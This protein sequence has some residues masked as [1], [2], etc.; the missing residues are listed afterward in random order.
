M[1]SSDEE[2]ETVGRLPT[3]SEVR[4]PEEDG[5]V[6]AARS[7]RSQRNLAR[8]TGFKDPDRNT[9]HWDQLLR[10]M[11]WMAEDFIRERKWRLNQAKIFARRAS[12]ALQDHRVKDRHHCR[13]DTQRRMRKCAAIAREV[14]RFWR[15]A[16]RVVNFKVQQSIE[17]RKKEM[18][19][20]HL[21]FLVGQ[22]ERYSSMLAENLLGQEGGMVESNGI[23]DGGDA[24]GPSNQ[25]MV[26]KGNANELEQDDGPGITKRTV[27][28]EERL[29]D[30]RPSKRHRSE[31]ESGGPAEGEEGDPE[32]INSDILDAGDA[33]SESGSEEYEGEEQD[34]E[35]TLEE[36]EKLAAA[37]ASPSRR[38]NE[39]SCLE[40]EADLPLE[41]ILKSY[42]MVITEKCEVQRMPN[43]GENKEMDMEVG[44]SHRPRVNGLGSGEAGRNLR[45]RRAARRRDSPPNGR[46][47]TDFFFFDGGGNAGKK[48]VT[49]DGGGG[50]NATADAVVGAT[51]K[52]NG[53]S[54]PGHASADVE[55]K[56]DASVEEDIQHRGEGSGL[57][58][59]ELP[60]ETVVESSG[61]EASAELPR[62]K[63]DLDGGAGKAEE[64]EA[65]A[66]SKGKAVDTLEDDQRVSTGGQN[67]TDSN[68]LG[69][70]ADPDSSNLVDISKVASTAQPKGNTLSACDVRTNVPFLLKHTLREY[71]HIGLDWLVTL[72]R[73]R[74][75]GI[76]ADEMGLGKTIQTIS[77]LAWLACEEGVWGPHL[78]V[79]PTSVMLNWEMEFKKWCPAFKLLTYYGSAKE[80]KTKRQGWSKPNAFHVCITSY[81]L[82]LQDAKMFRRKK[83]KYLILDEAHMIKNWK[84]QRWQTLLKFNSK[85]RL[86]L[87]G[88]PLQ[89]ELMELWSLM[90]FLMPHVFSSHA[91]FKDWFCNPLTGMVQGQAEVNQNIVE[92]LHGVLRPFLLRRL[93]SEVERQLPQ[94]HEHVV[95]CRLSKRQRKLYEEY[96]A[97][98]ETRSTLTSGNFLGMINVLMQLRKVC[99]HPDLFAGRPI[100]SPWDIEPIQ[101]KYPSVAMGLIEPQGPWQQTNLGAMGFYPA[102]NERMSNWEAREIGATREDV[103]TLSKQDERVT[104]DLQVESRER[105]IKFRQEGVTEPALD[106]L[107]QFMHKTIQTRREWRML[108]AQHADKL[109]HIRCSQE[110]IY[111]CDLRK[112]VGCVHPVSDGTCLPRN[113]SNHP[114]SLREMIKSYTRRSSECDTMM[115]V[116]LCCIPKARAATPVHWCSK[117]TKDMIRLASRNRLHLEQECRRR[118]ALLWTPFVRSQLF[119]PDKRLVQFDCGKLQELALL[120]HTLRSGGHRVLIFTQMS[121]MLDIL[122]LFLN[123]HGFTYMR[124]DG[125]TKPEQRQILMQK[126]NNDSRTFAFILSTRSGGVGVNLTGADTVIFYDSDWNPAMDLQAQDRCHRIGQTREVHIYRLVTEHTIEENILRKSNEKR[127]LDFLAIQSGGFNLDFLQKLNPRDLLGGTSDDEIKAA[128][129]SAEDEADATAAAEAEKEAAAEL[130]EFTAD[131]PPV[132]QADR[133][134]PEIDLENEAEPEESPKQAPEADTPRNTDPPPAAPEV[135]ATGDDNSGEKGDGRRGGERQVEETGQKEQEGNGSDAGEDE[136]GFGGLNKGMV[137]SEEMVKLLESFT[138]I[139][140]FAIQSIEQ[141]AGKVDIEAAAHQLVA[142]VNEEEWELDAIEEQKEQEDQEID[143]EDELWVD[144]WDKTA[145]TAE[146]KTEVEAAQKEAEEERKRMEEYMLYAASLPPEPEP[147]TVPMRHSKRSKAKDSSTTN[148][149]PKRLRAPLSSTSSMTAS[150]DEMSDTQ[151]AFTRKRSRVNHAANPPPPRTLYDNLWQRINPPMLSGPQPWKVEDDLVLGFMVK[152]AIEGMALEGEKSVGGLLIPE[153]VWMAAAEALERGVSEPGAEFDEMET[154]SVP[155]RRSPRECKLR[156]SQLLMSFANSSIREAIQMPQNQ[157][158]FA[159]RDFQGILSRKVAEAISNAS[160]EEVMSLWRGMKPDGSSR[161]LPECFQTLQKTLNGF[162]WPGSDHGLRFNLDSGTR[163]VPLAADVVLSTIMQVHGERGTKLNK[164]LL[165]VLSDMD[166]VA[167]SGVLQQALRLALKGSKPRREVSG[168]SGSNLSEERL[169]GLPNQSGMKP[170]RMG[171]RDSDFWPPPPLPA[172]RGPPAN[173][174]ISY[175]PQAPRFPGQVNTSAQGPSLPFSSPLPPQY[176]TGGVRGLPTSFPQPTLP[177][178]PA[179]LPHGQQGYSLPPGVIFPYGGRGG[180]DVQHVPLPRPGVPKNAQP[181]DQTNRTAQILG[182]DSM[183]TLLKTLHPRDAALPVSAPGSSLQWTHLVPPHLQVVGSG[184]TSQPGPGYLP[185]STPQSMTPTFPGA[186]PPS[187]MY[188]FFPGGVGGQPGG[189]RRVG[190]APIGTPQSSE[191]FLRSLASAQALARGEKQRPPTQTGAVFGG[192]AQRGAISGIGHQPTSSGD[193]F[194]GLQRSIPLSQAES[195]SQ[196]RLPPGKYWTCG[197]NPLGGGG[198]ATTHQVIPE[199]LGE[200]LQE[201]GL[202]NVSYRDLTSSQ[203]QEQKIGG[204]HISL[205]DWRARHF[206]GR[207]KA[208]PGGAV[209]GAGAGVPINPKQNPAQSALAPLAM[210]GVSPSSGPLPLGL[211]DGAGAGIHGVQPFAGVGGGQR[212]QQPMLLISSPMP[213]ASGQMVQHFLVPISLSQL[214][215]YQTGGMNMQNLAFLPTIDRQLALRDPAV[216]GVGISGSMNSNVSAISSSGV[217]SDL[218]SG[219]QLEPSTSHGL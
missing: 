103:L 100:I 63:M 85:R 158:I 179:Y 149:P 190:A 72:Y 188:G 124:L 88:T 21:D 11:K 37:E 107:S 19:D 183:E 98:S 18:L 176:F 36:E 113:W 143:M 160:D 136:E 144:A 4:K 6:K 140:K 28:S 51:P 203:L 219:G 132:L 25:Q 207:E 151:A 189:S 202:K 181:P 84:S 17:R 78:I 130:A 137:G 208:G 210:M 69:E 129:R 187:P 22:T 64:L 92:R 138:P 164:R 5:V 116:F 156:Y 111:G 57:H 101:Y 195:L 201:M 167:T 56:D 7:I 89:N 73:K 9:T 166:K 155:A 55:Q 74:I 15:M 180:S 163:V 133:N 86:L 171:R 148:R 104:N 118:A 44:Q 154:G 108:R 83:W 47:E 168:R 61:T 142:D 191:D 99:N 170:E 159:L 46:D 105:I 106:V 182:A 77:L 192:N 112:A 45:S 12:R 209:G 161:T 52:A 193:V 26:E 117:P 82:I 157:C 197:V 211:P 2:M 145:A 62:S 31:E 200:K 80:R 8:A 114:P 14:Q 91:Q 3:A 90:H 1:A 102:W 53:N 93:K 95:H 10:E 24:A 131:P 119:F 13:D 94:K 216:G 178:G 212:A 76:L 87:T 20:K 96:M 58:E 66:P 35:G 54:D 194:V 172:Y 59:Q 184:G 127:H 153:G 29:L 125:S 198:G 177:T 115:K 215:T 42:G 122:E 150:D 32:V 38:E 75:N 79:V 135:G 123:L 213:T 146:Y 70:E 128:M 67:P 120:L 196:S 147:D 65:S 110:P 41:E 33:V 217:Q 48:F 60:N 121:K 30:T 134:D 141:M 206:A 16:E 152:H 50:K 126:F 204:E 40:N 175:R 218:K 185:V 23:A 71:Q 43:A 205:P 139:E 49:E 174:G 34:D 27:A 169:K 39:L 162:A 186:P 97:S 68:A 165:S 109:N 214:A 199:A 173:M 81:T